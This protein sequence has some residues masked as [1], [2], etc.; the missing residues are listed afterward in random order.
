VSKAFEF[1]ESFSKP[2][3][4]PHAAFQKWWE[5]CCLLFKR[6]LFI[7]NLFAAFQNWRDDPCRFSK[8]L[9]A[10]PRHLSSNRSKGFE[11]IGLKSLR[12]IQKLWALNS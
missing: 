8:A 4:L 9:G 5:L 3:R 1:A 6:E 10:T 11:L 2:A 7:G 12:Q